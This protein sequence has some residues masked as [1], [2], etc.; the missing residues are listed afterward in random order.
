M[1]QHSN[2]QSPPW[3]LFDKQFHIDPTR[4][5]PTPSDSESPDA[6]AYGFPSVQELA[7]SPTPLPSFGP[8]SN[9]D[10]HQLGHYVDPDALST[11]SAL[12]PASPSV[13]SPNIEALSVRSSS[14]KA[15]YASDDYACSNE[16]DGQAQMMSISTSFHPGSHSQVSDLVISSSDGV[17]FYLNSSIIRKASAAAVPCFLRYS[18]VP[19]AGINEAGIIPIPASAAVLNI[20]FHTIYGS[21]CAQNSPAT[22]DLV[23]AVDSLPTLGFRAGALVRPGNPTHDL[24]LS[25]APSQ[26][27]DV[28]ALAAH[29]HLSELAIHASSYLLSYPLFKVDDA[30]AARIGTSYLKR[31]FLLHLERVKTVKQIL[32][33]PPSLHPM[34]K[35]CNLQD[36]KK[37]ARLWALGSTYLAWDIGPDLSTRTIQSVYGPLVENLTCADCQ[38][39]LK[40]RVRDVVTKWVAVKTTI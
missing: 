40:K 11:L 14:A 29:H 32:A 10:Y 33:Q 7:Q 16:D 36:Q 8:F 26:P 6:H 22:D 37:V 13:Y 15:S 34:R 35:D 21:S 24:L 39:M 25:R 20:I 17:L 38:E 30:L 12:S 28:F 2:P 31:L 19:G 1:Q 5:Y 23:N 27:M 18:T 3:A 4:L 9:N